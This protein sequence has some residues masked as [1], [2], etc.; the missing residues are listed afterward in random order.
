MA[1][2]WNRAVE[3]QR[4]RRDPADFSHLQA[5]GRCC[6]Y[7]G[8]GWRPGLLLELDPEAGAAVVGRHIGG[9]V[10]VFRVVDGRNVMPLAGGGR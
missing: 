5:P 10:D 4:M 2:H 7:T 3:R 8:R 6:W 9:D 1:R